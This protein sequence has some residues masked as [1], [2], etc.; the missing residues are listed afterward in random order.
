MEDLIYSISKEPTDEE[1]RDRMASLFDKELEK[2][3]SERFVEL[4]G[5]TLIRIGDDLQTAV[6]ENQR[7]RQDDEN[8]E[9]LLASINDRD[10]RM[11]IW[12]L[13]DMMV[14]SKVLAKKALD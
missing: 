7:L 3:S 14:Q 6:K 11:Q 4:F 9:S 5:S 12:A 13:V 10:D 2:D 8:D 1:R